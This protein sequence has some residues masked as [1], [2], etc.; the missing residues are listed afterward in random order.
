[1]NG[2]EERAE[3][4]SEVIQESFKKELEDKENIGVMFSG[5]VDSALIALLASRYAENVNLYATG[6]EGSKDLVSARDIADQLGMNLREAVVDKENIEDLL[7]ESISILEEFD[8]IDIELGVPIIICS[9]MASQ[10]GMDYLALGQGSEELY[11]GYRR[12]EKAIEEGKDLKKMLKEEVKNLSETEIAR[13]D[14]V[15][16]KFGLKGL[17]PFLNSEIVEESLKIPAEMKITEKYKK[18]VL[19]IAAKKLG[20]PEDSWKRPKKAMQYGSGIHKIIEKLPKEKGI[21]KK[22]SKEQ[23]FYGPIQKHFYQLWT[24]VKGKEPNIEVQK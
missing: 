4:L 13:D 12:H 22:V 11:A 6:I 17:Y 7:R 24:E 14:K 3:H 5:G 9:R 20:V 19:R 1:M 10:D 21:D 8:V 15:I 18:H 2:I 23:G 16:E